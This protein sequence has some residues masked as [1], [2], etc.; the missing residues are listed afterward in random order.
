MNAF[1][2]A[3]EILL[4]IVRSAEHVETWGMQLPDRL[5]CEA[6]MALHHYPSWVELAWAADEQRSM[7]TWMAREAAD[8]KQQ[9]DAHARLKAIAARIGVESAPG[10]LKSDGLGYLSAW[11]FTEHP[12]LGYRQPIDRLYMAGDPE[13]IV[14][15]FKIEASVS[16]EAKRLFKSERQAN[17]WLRRIDE[18]LGRIPLEMLGTDAGRRLVMDSLRRLAARLSVT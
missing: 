11:L 12:A 17:L 10:D 13:V 15:L 16:S 8:T 6:E 14:E 2:R 4:D 1:L 3:G 5:V 18:T 9:K 7:H